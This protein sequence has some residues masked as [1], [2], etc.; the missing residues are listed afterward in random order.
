M[1]IH[2]NQIKTANNVVGD[3]VFFFFCKSSD[4]VEWSR[5]FLNH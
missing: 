4:A 5:F 1:Y 2:V 3:L